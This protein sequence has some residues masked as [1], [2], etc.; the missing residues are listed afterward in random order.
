MIKD[1]RM[2]SWRRSMEIALSTK[3]KVG[4]VNGTVLRSAYAADPVKVEQWDTCNSM[5]IFWIHG[6][7]SDTIKKFVLFVN[8][9]RETWI[10]L[11]KCFSISNGSRK[12]KLN[13][14]LYSL[15]QNGNSINVYFTSMSSLWEEIDVVNALPVVTESN[16]KIR[17]LLSAISKY[18]EEQK[19]FQFLNGLDEHFGAM[20]KQLLILIPLTTVESACSLL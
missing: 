10:Q 3:K 5:V 20:R 7:L 18:Q 4:F 14:D 8:T 9:S 16:A 1:D 2:R 6:C 12:Y 11:E 13:K 19:L 15:K 17:S